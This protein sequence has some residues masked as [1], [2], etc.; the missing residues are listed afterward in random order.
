VQTRL[1]L[2]D[3]VTGEHDIRQEH[4]R[5][6]ERYI[7]PQVRLGNVGVW[8]GGLASRAGRESFN[9]YLA[10][11]RGRVV[12]NRIE[13]LAGRR[14]GLY[15]TSFG[16]GQSNY[17]TENSEHY[18]S[19]LVVVT[20]M[21]RPPAPRR[22]TRS[23]PLPFFHKFKITLTAGI[24]G[25]EIISV[26]RYHFI[27]DYDDHDLN[28]PPSHPARYAFTGGGF[29]G[30]APVAASGGIEWNR[31]AL[32]GNATPGD[33]GGWARMGSAGISAGPG[34]GIGTLRLMPDTKPEVYLPNF[35]SSVS[36]SIGA[37]IIT[38]PFSREG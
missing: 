33:F 19:V 38:G 24:E 29:G 20:R 12:A 1:L 5:G 30:G 31:F 27:I 22:V 15:A 2:Y 14:I 32:Q 16:E 34:V 9:L 21:P 35:Q 13:Y 4:Q 11:A 37:S 18:R 10:H 28:S 26:G 3:F 17:G 23:Q 7:L 25:G 36:L 8:V 6:I